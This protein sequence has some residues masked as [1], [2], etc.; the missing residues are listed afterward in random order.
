MASSH[1]WTK[2]QIKDHFEAANALGE[3][4]NEV[5][6]FIKSKQKNVYEKDVVDFVKKSYKK[7]G[8]I[9]DDKKVQCIAAFKENTANVHYFVKGK[10][11]KLQP[12]NLIL[13][14]IWARLNKRN[15]PYADMTWMFFCGTKIPKDI[16]KTWK[17]LSKS[18]DKAVKHI[19]KEIKKNI[20][21]R[22][23]DI[24]RASNDY[25]GEN[26]F[27]DGLKPA[28]G[29]ALGF[30]SPHGKFPSLNWKEYSRILKNIGYTIEP[31]MYF[32]TFGMRTEIDFY[33][34]TENKVVITTPVQKEITLI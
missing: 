24:S 12:N 20:L 29:H 11:K 3:I 8:L 19:E 23:V 28:W 7:H 33:I 15:T 31:G 6:E 2:T 17:V 30:D 27:A 16:E 25:I 21:P 10:G 22:C 18:L 13:L 9:N 26:G 1:S 14:D 5:A 32:K 4:K 34:S